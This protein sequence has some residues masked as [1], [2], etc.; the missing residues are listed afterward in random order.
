LHF[1]LVG[2]NPD[3]P[4]AFVTNGVTLI[5]LWQAEDGAA[6]FDQRRQIGLHHAEFTVE[7]LETLAVLY[8]K[9]QPW[10]EVEIEGEISPPSPG[11]QARHFLLRMPGGP[12]LKFRVTAVVS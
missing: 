11:S 7:N 6:P 8:D 10:Q 9:L 4:A 3:Y 2:A 5:T 1:K 12:R